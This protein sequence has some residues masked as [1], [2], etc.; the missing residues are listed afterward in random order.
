MPM[1]TH[2]LMTVT[3]FIQKVIHW[4]LLSVI[5]GL[6]MVIN[7]LWRVIWMVLSLVLLSVITCYGWLL[8]VIG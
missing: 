8:S 6:R 3:Q 2:R 7:W 4:W 5:I 1:H